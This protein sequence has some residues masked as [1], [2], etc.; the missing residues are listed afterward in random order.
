M[1]QD[2]VGR[3]SVSP[4][5]IEYGI[6]I[7]YGVSIEYGSY[8]EY[9]PLNSITDSGPIEFHVSSGRQ[10]FLYILQILSYSSKLKITRSNGK[11]ITDANHVGRVT[12]SY[13]AY[14]YKSTSR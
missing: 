6:N 2:R 11:K 8:I 7:D 10:S 14:S 12:C 4:I 1:L 5:S 9:H 3:F 13:I